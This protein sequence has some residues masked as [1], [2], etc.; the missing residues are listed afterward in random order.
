MPFFAGELPI[1]NPS[2]P[3]GSAAAYKDAHP[4]DISAPDIVY[5]AEDDDAI[6]TYIRN[7][8]K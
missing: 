3:Q 4:V 5:S 7:S 1:G 8:S 6:D 2:F